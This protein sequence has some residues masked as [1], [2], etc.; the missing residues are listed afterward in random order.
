M[1]TVRVDTVS[2]YTSA[3]GIT[4]DGVVIKDLPAGPTTVDEVKAVTYSTKP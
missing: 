1:S 3:N 4:I 2:E